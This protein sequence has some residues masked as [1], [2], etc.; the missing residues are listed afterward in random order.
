[1][2]TQVAVYCRADSGTNP[3]IRRAA[4][5]M[6]YWRLK[7]YARE[8]G[9]QITAYYEDS[10]FSALEPDRPG[11]QKLM[12]DFQDGKFQTLLVVN[13][14]RLSRGQIGNLKSWPFP[15]ESIHPL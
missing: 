13:M 1:M 6:Q 14:D 5:E 8:R 10:G 15:I 11:L 9:F 4:L 12:A 2:K 3:E 7:E